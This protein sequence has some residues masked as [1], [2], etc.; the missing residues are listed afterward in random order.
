MTDRHD[1]MT[2]HIDSSC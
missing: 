1:N 2:W